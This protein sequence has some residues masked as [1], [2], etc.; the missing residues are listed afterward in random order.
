MKNCPTLAQPFFVKI[1]TKHLPR[2]K[3]A[4]ILGATFVP[5]KNWPK[6]TIAQ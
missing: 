4:R 2:L 5:N 3:V 1:K 6:I